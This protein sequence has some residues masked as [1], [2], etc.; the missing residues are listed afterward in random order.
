LRKNNKEF[1]AFV[2][3]QERLPTISRKL[4]A[5]LI[6]PIQR[7]P[8]YLL[9]I[10]QLIAQTDGDEERGVLNAARKQIESV[11]RHINEQ[12]REQENMQRIVQLQRSLAHGRPKIVYPGR[13]IIHEGSLKK[14]S[15]RDSAHQRY[16]VL[17]NDMLLYCKVRRSDVNQRGSLLCSCILPLRHCKAEAVMGDGL[18]KVKCKEECLLLC[19]NTAEEGKRWVDVINEAVAQLQRNYRTLKKES[20]SRRPQ[21]KRH[22]P[23]QGQESLLQI[24]HKRQ[25]VEKRAAKDQEAADQ[26]NIENLKFRGE[27]S[28]VEEPLQAKSARSFK[29]PRKLMDLSHSPCKM[30]RT[31]SNSPATEE[32]FPVFYSPP[33]Q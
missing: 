25:V 22:L 17:F 4:E 18:F 10:S 14:V 24:L 13:R 1:E 33:I 11:T 23:Q 30:L 21:K 16:F 32:E 19:S 15:D 29:L 31:K 9:L 6:V 28:R 12:I 20:S 3:Q 5:L 2:C 26:L 7:V 8:R 27:I